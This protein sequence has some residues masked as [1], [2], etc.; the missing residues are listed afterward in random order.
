MK[1]TLILPRRGFTLI[2]LLVV[3]SIIAILAG[4]LFPVANSLRETAR[5]TSCGSNQR[6]I[7][8][9]MLTYAQNNSARWPRM[10]VTNGE[11]TY[12]F[13]SNNSYDNLSVVPAADAGLS[14]V[15]DT[16]A[17]LLSD[18]AA[19]TVGTKT[20]QCPA[21]DKLMRAG[22][23]ND[24]MALAASY[25]YDYGTMPDS[26]AERVVLGDRPHGAGTQRSSAALTSPHRSLVMIAFADGHVD[27][28]RLAA[29]TGSNVTTEFFLNGSGNVDYQPAVA[30]QLLPFAVTADRNLF[31]QQGDDVLQANGS[32]NRAWLR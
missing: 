12:P 29:G 27:Q 14:T 31:D 18:R 7:V 30:A 11:F 26:G 4:I 15:V 1:F 23:A 32:R 19:G 9:D 21:S 20:F 16:F 28:Q 10:K 22:L 17:F 6:M 8:M 2:E 25:A 3:V 24:P 5:R 13:S